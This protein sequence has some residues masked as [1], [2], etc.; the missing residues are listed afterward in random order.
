MDF[1]NILLV[2]CNALCFPWQVRNTTALDWCIDDN[3]IKVRTVRYLRD[4][5]HH[6]ILNVY[7][8]DLIANPRG[9]F[10]MLCDFV[11]V[12]CYTAF[13]E[14]AKNDL[15]SKLSRTRY[16]I[17][18]SNE[19]KEK[20][21]REIQKFYCLKS[22]FSFESDYYHHKGLSTFLK[23]WHEMY[24]NVYIS[25]ALRPCIIPPSFLSVLIW[26]EKNAI[27]KFQKGFWW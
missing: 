15:Y 9:T 22:H 16:M 17:E 3:F 25:F 7:N 8:R 23:S 21:T 13:V 19:R 10:Q 20:V 5:S 14:L 11:S 24:Y 12:S 27:S 4:L 26:T 6:Q 2:S 1:L 18:W